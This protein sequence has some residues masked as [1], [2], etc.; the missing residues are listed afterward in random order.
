MEVAWKAAKD[1]EIWA[2]VHIRSN[3]SDATYHKF[4]SPDSEEYYSSY[5]KNLDSKTL[6]AFEKPTKHD[7]QIEEFN[8]LF[9]SKITVHA[10]MT[11]KIVTLTTMRNFFNQYQDFI[12]DMLRINNWNFKLAKLP[13]EMQN[14]I[15][16]KYKE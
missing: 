9:N 5:I 4:E 3:F 15:Y 13:I 11:N 8:P 6:E 10:D 12:K 1:L 14:P 16:G 2:I 7:F